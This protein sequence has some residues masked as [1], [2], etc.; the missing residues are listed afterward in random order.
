MQKNYRKKELEQ[1]TDHL[2]ENMKELIMTSEN[3]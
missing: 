2:Y 3:H 1:F